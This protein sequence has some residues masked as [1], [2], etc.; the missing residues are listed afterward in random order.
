MLGIVEH[1][2]RDVGAWFD[3]TIVGTLKALL[4]RDTWVRDTWVR[5]TASFCNTLQHIRRPHH[6]VMF[7]RDSM[8]RCTNDFPLTVACYSAND[9]TWFLSRPTQHSVFRRS[10]QLT[11][12]VLVSVNSDVV[13]NECHKW[14]TPRSTSRTMKNDLTEPTTTSDIWRVCMMTCQTSKEYVY[15]D[16][17]SDVEGA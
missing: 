11:V 8:S 7:A 17:M 9:G 2:T 14:K 10:G 6:G 3:F 4:V 1:H 16:K 5:Q 13:T 12:I 15:H